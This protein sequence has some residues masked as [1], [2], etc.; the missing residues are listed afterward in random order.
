MKK[1]IISINNFTPIIVAPPT[2]GQKKKLI[3]NKLSFEIVRVFAATPGKRG[4][5]NCLCRVEYGY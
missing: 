4:N 2:L 1:Y 5:D 3:L